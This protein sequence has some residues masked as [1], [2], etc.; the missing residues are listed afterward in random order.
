MKSN[1]YA[2]KFKA[3]FS[4]FVDQQFGDCVRTMSTKGH[5]ELSDNTQQIIIIERNYN[6]R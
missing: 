6:D 3:S 5:V 4:S 1:L 2:I